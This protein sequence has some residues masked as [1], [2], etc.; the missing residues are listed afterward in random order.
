MQNTIVPLAHIY[1]LHSILPGLQRSRNE[2]GYRERRG[3]KEK[4]KQV[5]GR[6]YS[7]KKFLHY[8]VAQWVERIINFDTSKARS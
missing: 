5:S 3:D 4:W 2:T 1:V 7:S 6:S 8:C